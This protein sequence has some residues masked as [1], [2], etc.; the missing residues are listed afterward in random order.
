MALST[1]HSSPTTSIWSRKLDLIY[2]VFLS[3]LTFLALT[4][5]F[6]PLYPIPLPSWCQALYTY[7]RTHY[8]D[9][10]YARDPPFFRFYVALEVVYNVPVSLWA[11]RGL[12]KD[13]IMTPVHLLVFATH[14]VVSTVVCLVE[15]LGAEDW[16]RESVRKNVPGYVLFLGIA[17]VLWVDMFGRVRARVLGKAKVN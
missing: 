6:I 7:Y 8:N 13:D 3:L 5:D 17:V 16:P 14:L 11:I 10:L 2:I 12:V 4:L 9:P 15:V 1:H